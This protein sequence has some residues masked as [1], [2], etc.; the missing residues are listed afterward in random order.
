MLGVVG[1][2]Q[3]SGSGSW[4]LGKDRDA[5]IWDRSGA[6]TRYCQYCGS[7]SEDLE[8]HW[9]AAVRDRIVGL[10]VDRLTVAWR[11]SW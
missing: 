9:C 8:A 5:A 10:V 2:I 6:V 4:E 3:Y 11:I 1:F 7:I